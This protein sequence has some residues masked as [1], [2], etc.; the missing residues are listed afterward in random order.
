MWHWLK[1]WRDWAM[2]DLWPMQRLGLRPQALHFSYEK[3]GLSVP[4]QPIPWNAEA[5]V[6]EALVRLPAGRSPADFQLRVNTQLIT[7]ETIRREEGD[8]RHH[9]FFRLQPPTQTVTAELLWRTTSLGEVILPVLGREEFIGGIRVM[10][11]ALFVQV[12][13]QS[14]ACQ[15]FVASQCKGLLASAVITSPTSLAPLRDLGLQVE[16][17]AEK[18]NSAFTVN[19]PLTSSQLAGRQALVSLVPPKFPRRVGNWTITWLV[20]DG[21]LLTHRF[22]AISQA[23]FQRSLRVCDTRFLVQSAKHGMRLM[24]QVPPLDKEDRVGP[25]FLVASGEAGMAGLCT[26][27]IHAQVAKGD[28]MPQISEQ[29]V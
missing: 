3:A 11:P 1:R 14:V 2:N 12:G 9:L 21:P 15:T 29:E 27:R 8:E 4:D 17:R 28:T 26:L 5:V 10:M 22:R 23:G 25:C 24:R 19:V 20:G 7:A 6:V 16:F 18:R 13:E